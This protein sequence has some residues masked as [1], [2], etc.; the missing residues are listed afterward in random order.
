[1]P[2]PLRPGRRARPGRLAVHPEGSNDPDLPAHRP[3]AARNG[4]G[5][6]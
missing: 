5:R 4:H 1:V 2:G 6:L 3:P